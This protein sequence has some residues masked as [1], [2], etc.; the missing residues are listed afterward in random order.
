MKT[1]KNMRN[2]NQLDFI[3][4]MIFM[5]FQLVIIISAGGNQIKIYSTYMYRYVGEGYARLSL[6]RFI[7]GL[8]SVQHV[9][10]CHY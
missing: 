4:Y 3:I 7:V 5:I 1:L 9:A 2:S 10:S 8:F 6:Y